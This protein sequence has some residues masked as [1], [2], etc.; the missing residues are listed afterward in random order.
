MAPA[1]V[2]CTTMRKK[3]F[4]GKAAPE[5]V[6]PMRLYDTLVNSAPGLISHLDLK[7]IVRSSNR[8]PQ[9]VIRD[10]VVGSHWLSFVAEAHQE[11]LAQAFERTIARRETGECE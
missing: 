3:R 11:R 10:Q 1:H 2:L 5:P 4:T 7:G 8:L 9:G 6:L